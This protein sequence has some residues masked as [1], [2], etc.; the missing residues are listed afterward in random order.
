MEL[1]GVGVELSAA[2][3]EELLEPLL[4]IR[5]RGEHASNEPS[6]AFVLTAGVRRGHSVARPILAVPAER[7]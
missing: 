1:L 3:G 6:A 7:S 5:A 4:G 2:L